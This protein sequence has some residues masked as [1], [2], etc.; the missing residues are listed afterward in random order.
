V[1]A[2]AAL[3]AAAVIVGCDEC[4][5]S[6]RLGAACPGCAQLALEVPELPAPAAVDRAQLELP[7]IRSSCH[8]W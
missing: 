8:A 3:E 6:V 5:A 2:A 1:I 4:G 7:G